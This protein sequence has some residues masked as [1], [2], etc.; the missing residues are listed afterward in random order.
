MT[1]P[2]IIAAG[3]T[4][5]HFFPAEALAAEL[6]DRGRT[7]A[8]MTDARSGA[9]SSAVFANCERFVL[10]GSGIAGRGVLKAGRS[11]IALAAGTLQARRIIHQLR[12]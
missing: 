9:G 7:V 11:V 8:L 2:I 12:P 6:Q 5:G 4:G 3:G 10:K 1:G